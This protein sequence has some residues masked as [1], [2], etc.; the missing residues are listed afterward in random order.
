MDRDAELRELMQREIKRYQGLLLYKERQQLKRGDFES[1]A[2]TLIDGD[3]TR[4]ARAPMFVTSKLVVRPRLPEPPAGSFF[5]EIAV[6]V[7]TAPLA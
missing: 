6:T 7:T 5:L 1:I 3:T 2:R 4:V